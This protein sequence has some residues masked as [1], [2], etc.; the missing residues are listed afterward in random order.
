M[1]RTLYRDTAN[2]K[3]GG[4]CAGM[5]DYFGME[6]WLVRVLT[7]S[8]FL[9]GFG[10]L[11]LVLYVAMVLILDPMP[12]DQHQKAKQHREH[13]I[14]QKAWQSGKSPRS[15]LS[16]IERELED[17]EDAIERMEACVT[18]KEFELKRQFS[19]L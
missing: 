3:L 2:G 7:I 14:K 19:K 4:V 12:Q 15:L 11:I 1:S 8:A 16:N 13:N 18:S 17:I 5:A 10:A 9:L 6:V